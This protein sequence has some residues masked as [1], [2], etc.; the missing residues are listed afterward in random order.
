MK[1]SV[2]SQAARA[3][4]TRERILV[5]TA[6][7]ADAVAPYYEKLSDI[8]SAVF[9][10]AVKGF[11]YGFLPFVIFLGVV[12]HELRTLPARLPTSRHRPSHPS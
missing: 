9:P 10:Y 5:M 2:V 3:V 1:S 4:V 12:S 7:L 6:P 11:H 8:Y